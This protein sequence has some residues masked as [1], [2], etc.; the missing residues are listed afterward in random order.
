MRKG[1]LITGIIL[2]LIGL[3]FSLIPFF[4]IKILFF[5]WIYSIPIL[6]IGI[7]ILKNKEDEIEGIKDSSISKSKK[8][9]KETIKYHK[10][11][12]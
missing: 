10:V 12:Q 3:I 6:I 5:M 8:F 1:Q 7:V 11:K 2:V 9:E 4:S